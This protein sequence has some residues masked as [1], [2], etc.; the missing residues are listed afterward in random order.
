[1][2]RR[3]LIRPSLALI[4]VSLLAAACGG[5]S[6][7]TSTSDSSQGVVLRGSVTGMGALSPGLAG[8]LSRSA[9]VITV[10]VAENTAFTTTV[11][12]DGSFTLRGLP[13]GSFTLVFTSGGAEIGR[14]TF[15]EVKPNQEITLTVA[16]A[17]GSVV[18]LEESRN[19]IG[20]GD[21]EIEGNVGSVTMLN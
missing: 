3:N 12:A 18:L 11:G 17:S 8:S 9:A 4:F 21:I 20:H 13:P 1:M 5:G 14:L 7:P 10:T 6:S 19:G 2:T 16:V 15:S